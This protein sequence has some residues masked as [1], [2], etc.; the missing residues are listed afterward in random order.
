MTDLLKNLIFTDET[1]ARD[2][3]EARIWA[4]TLSQ[5]FMSHLQGKG[6]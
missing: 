2:W 6:S 3:L 4:K 5:S 1:K